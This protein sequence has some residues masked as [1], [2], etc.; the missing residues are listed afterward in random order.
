MSLASRQPVGIFPGPAAYLLL[1]EVEDDC[2]ALDRILRG[3]LEGEC[4]PA[5]RFFVAA[6][7]GRV[8]EGLELTR[9]DDDALTAFN[10][11][12]LAPS[13]EQLDACQDRLAGE[14]LE[15]SRCVAYTC[16]LND[17]PPT[18]EGLSGE[19]L[20]MALAAASAVDLEASRS[21]AAAE[22]L[23]RAAAAARE[24]SPVFAAMLFGQRC[25]VLASQPQPAVALAMADLNEALRLAQ[26]SRVPTLQAELLTKQG[27]LLQGSAGG[28]R[29][30]MLAAIRCYQS[31]LQHGVTEE[32][33]PE[34][35]AQLQNNLGL[36]Y[37]S[38]PEEGAGGHL[39]AGLAVQSFRH[40]LKTYTREAHPDMWA[41]VS[42]NLANALQHAPSSHRQDNLIQAVETYEEVLQVRVREKDPV[43]Y[44]MVLLN[45][46]NSLAHLGIFKPA[47]EKLAEACKLFS[48]HERHEQAATARE[49]ID[50][51]T[52]QKEAVAAAAEP[53]AN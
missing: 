43:A 37:L 39:R 25:D 10:R 17:S 12:V 5:W 46:A 19:L 33:H 15:F 30:A 53:V 28:S 20:A 7:A 1:P 3:E 22:K 9:G 36:A 42:M 4:P 21:D 31:A 32:D 34:W 40:A 41:S 45:Q 27:M 51:I 44:A 24:N 13:A 35:F 52:E 6:A 49:L 23:K 26:S 16:G 8:E 48:W 38:M 14:L 50:L 29:G 47:L 2:G 11:F 18:G